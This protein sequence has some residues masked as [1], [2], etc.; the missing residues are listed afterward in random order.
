[1]KFKFLF[2]LFILNLIYIYPDKEI[3]LWTET[4]GPPGGRFDIIEINPKN[5]DVLYAGSNYGFFRSDD[6]AKTWHRVNDFHK[7]RFSLEL[8]VK[9]IIFDPYDPKIVYVATT[10]G[11]FNTTDNGL[12]WNCLTG[13][14]KRVDVIAIGVDP[15]DTN[16]LYMITRGN[17]KSAVI[18][19]STDRGL[20]WIESSNGFDIP[21]WSGKAVIRVT[22]HN[23]IYAGGGSLMGLK[24]NLFYSSNGGKAWKEKYIGQ[25]EE[26]F[27]SS[28]KMDPLN[29]KHFY[30][31][32][33]DAH[34]RPRKIR[35]LLFETLDAG[36]TWKPIGDRNREIGCIDD[37]EI[38]TKN[39]NV[40]F[41][42]GP[43]SRS[44]DG[45][46]T[47]EYIGS[48]QNIKDFGRAEI[49]NVALNPDNENI[50]YAA[51]LGQGVAKSRDGGKTWWLAN[52][53]L[54]SSVITNI[55]ADPGNPDIIYASGGDG[56]GTWKTIDG[57]K[58]WIVLN[59]GGIDHPWVD[60][61]TI[62]PSNSSVLYDI[63]DIGRIFK[64]VD[65]GNSWEL[66]NND[67]MFTSI[68]NIEIDPTNLDII[69][70][71][72]NGYGIFKSYNGG[73]SWKYLLNSPDYSY[74]I[75]VDPD[76]PRIIYSGYTRKYFEKS[77][78]IFKSSN[79]GE[80]WGIVFEVE[81]SEGIKSIDIDKSNSNRVLA[82]SIG[83]RG[84]IY[85]SKDKGKS[86]NLITD[87]FT[88]TSIHSLETDNKNNILYAGTWGG[89]IYTTKNTGRTWLKLEEGPRYPSE[90]KVHVNSPEIIYSTSGVKPQV[91]KSTDSGKTWKLLFDAG[92]E[93]S[94]MISLEVDPLKKDTIYVSALKKDKYSKDLPTKDSYFQGSIFMIENNKIKNITSNLPRGVVKLT[95]APDNPEI[96]Y[97]CCELYGI[98]KTDNK[99]NKWVKLNG[100]PDREVISFAVNPRNPDILYAG[101]VLNGITNYGQSPAFSFPIDL[102]YPGG[103]CGL[104]K[105]MDGGKT[106]KN[107]NNKKIGQVEIRS[108]LID[109]KDP[110]LIYV[111]TN[112]DVYKI[113]SNGNSWRSE[114]SFS[115]KDCGNLVILNNYIFTGSHGTGVIKGKIVGKNEIKWDKSIGPVI[116][117]SDILIKIDPKNPGTIYASSYPGGMFKSLDGGNTWYE[118][119]TGLFCTVVDPNRQVYYNFDMDPEDT[120][121]LYLALF[122]V[123]VHRSLNGGD[124]WETLN[125]RSGE[126]NEKALSQVKVNIQNNKEIYISSPEGV[127]YT[128]NKGQ[129]WYRIINGLKNYD[130]YSIAVDKNGRI[131]SGNRGYGIYKLNK[132]KMIWKRTRDVTNFG[133]HWWV[134]NRP[135]YL[136]NALLINPE[137]SKI[138]YLGT[139]P[140]GFYKTTD[141]GKT[142]YESNIKFTIDGAFSMTFH[143][144]NYNIIY[145]G[146]YNGI[147]KSIDSGKTWRKIDKGIPPEQWVF[148]IV[149]DPDN[150]DILYAASK[151]GENKGNGRENFHGVVLK[152]IDGGESWFEIM[153]GLD[154][155]REYYQL[156]MYPEN[157]DVLFVSASDGVYMTKDGGGNWESIN[158][159]IDIG[160]GVT[161]NV[162]NNLKLDADHRYLYLGT[163]GKGVFK[164]DLKKLD[165]K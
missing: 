35:E 18:Y 14:D 46:K 32:F 54:I 27:V 107:I 90:I 21:A 109:E 5:P 41:Y 48:F 6:A 127:F 100:L 39:N 102:P 154:R 77:S 128:D 141:G 91:Y 117:V 95:I 113:T 34:N 40:I 89:G 157:H 71:A 142:W 108:I 101:T 8:Y 97:A 87:D 134:W 55:V 144:D 123:G 78:K 51:L 37:I 66:I 135:L 26:T 163:M 15:S 72:N 80:D 38:S 16:I 47:W 17:Q 145:S 44:N 68:L 28:I 94:R 61:L 59:K 70:A 121:V 86:W 118:K 67:F 73:E 150:P 103:T 122:G 88:F 148:S 165:L 139:F 22:R 24:G 111:T 49:T 75:K 115:Y 140:T 99:G 98:Y 81:G 146:T 82:G 13:F 9:S 30:I 79:S 76:D 3:L 112:S 25:G 156:I 151:N 155:G 1:M 160:T 63:A 33:G 29:K 129:S 19:K 7:N 84:E 96:L 152:S 43:L 125:G 131:Y 65:A 104:Y 133:V 149:I 114:S 105:S 50:I 74:V 4:S 20:K 120:N 93:Y 138:M 137:N 42:L 143:P 110:D 57:G 147:S 161:N 158:Y 56:T 124:S 58:N 62:D 126:L 130:M 106:W 31:G 53:G 132:E 159:N 2:F 162:A 36:K 60:E 69:Y 10:M 85:E 11:L 12:T 153:N 119:N 64:S 164:A 116:R 92:K 23:E 136:Y 45:G 83:K 52:K